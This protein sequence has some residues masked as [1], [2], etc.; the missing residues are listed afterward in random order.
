MPAKEQ[1]HHVDINLTIEEANTVLEAL[2]H[3]P[4]MR[5]Y[6]IIEKIH[7]QAQAGKQPKPAARAKKK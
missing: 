1:T 7:L 3:L 6:R 5:V 2:G 4:F